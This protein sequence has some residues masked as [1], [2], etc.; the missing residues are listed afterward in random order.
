M[1]GKN[2]RRRWYKNK[3]KNTLQHQENIATLPSFENSNNSMCKF[4]LTLQFT[5]KEYAEREARSLAG[6]LECTMTDKK[7]IRLI[8]ETA[9]SFETTRHAWAKAKYPKARAIIAHH[10]VAAA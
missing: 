4:I 5:E 8:I 1:N 9:S 6:I 7:S 10:N 2:R 3:N